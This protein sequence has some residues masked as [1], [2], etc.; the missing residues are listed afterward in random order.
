MRL[1]TP[2]II[3]YSL[4][5]AITVSW[6]VFLQILVTGQRLFLSTATRING[7]E[8][9][10]LLCRLPVKSSWISS[11]GVLGCSIFGFFGLWYL[12]FQTLTG[13]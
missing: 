8:S 12:E 5:N 2:Y 6:F 3:M 10:F 4:E 1:R 11:P 7:V 9:S 13:I